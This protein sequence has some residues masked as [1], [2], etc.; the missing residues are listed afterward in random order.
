LLH[1]PFEGGRS[2]S[3]LTFLDEYL[4]VFTHNI[5]IPNAYTP[6]SNAEVAPSILSIVYRSI[7]TLRG[8][9]I[10]IV[11]RIEP[12]HSAHSKNRTSA[13]MPIMT[14]CEKIF[15]SVFIRGLLAHTSLSE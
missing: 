12:I 6:Q 15:V 1:N 14:E 2:F 9:Y 5:N 4:V 10:S 13:G 8:A 7:F 11:Y 3:V